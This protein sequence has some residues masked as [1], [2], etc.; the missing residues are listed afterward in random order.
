MKN[1]LPNFRDLHERV[2]NYE[3]PSLFLDVLE[4]SLPS[5]IWILNSLKTYSRLNTLENS[6]LVIQDDLWEWFALSVI[7]DFLLLCF[8]MSPNFYPA[9]YGETKQKLDKYNEEVLVKSG[10]AQLINEI[11]DWK[12]P[13]LDFSQYRIFF[14]KLGFTVCYQN[15][16]DPFY[17]EIVEVIEDPG[18]MSAPVI[19]KIY[20]PGL[21]F[22]DMLFSRAGVQVRCKQ[23]I[24]VK[25][26]AENSVLYF[27]NR[28]HRRLTE[29]LSHGW[30]SNSRWRTNFRRDYETTT[31]FYYNVDGKYILGGEPSLPINA[32]KQ[33]DVETLTLEEQ[34]ELVI[35]RCF[36]QCVKENDNRWPY[37]DQLT[38]LKPT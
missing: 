11:N 32:S 1:A 23:G 3:G 17:Y 34:I 10:H 35:H 8:Q 9:I 24:F 31:H 7:N 5:A 20:W 16:F 12:G 14:E 25:D 30:G 38:V 19:E 28:R 13:A 18:W 6:Y 36:V 29:D 22:G 37:D 27:T 4:P 33:Y 2:V 21:K 15:A 26:I